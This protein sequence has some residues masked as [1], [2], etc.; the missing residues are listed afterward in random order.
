M[1]KYGIMGKK[2]KGKNLDETDDRN[3]TSMCMSNRD[4]RVHFG[5]RK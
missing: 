4:D 2:E 3:H 1:G 5:A